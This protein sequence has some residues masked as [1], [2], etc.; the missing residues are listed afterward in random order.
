MYTTKLT[1]SRRCHTAQKDECCTHCAAR[2]TST[3]S[4][5]PLDSRKR[6]SR[7]HSVCRSPGWVSPASA[8]WH[9]C[10]MIHWLLGMVQAAPLK[11]IQQH[12][13]QVNV[14]LDK[15]VATHLH[16]PAAAGRGQGRTAQ[17]ACD[18]SAKTLQQRHQSDATT[19]ATQHAMH[20]PL[21]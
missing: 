9:W 10:H 4:R 1:T 5:S 15:R 12:L 18:A 19:R 17:T 16:K 20:L 2:G 3:T 21:P 8:A 13:L 7:M 14:S 6:L 11:C